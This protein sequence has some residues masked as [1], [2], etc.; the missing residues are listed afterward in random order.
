MMRK[1][2]AFSLI[3]LLVVLT[4]L[5]VIISAT[6]VC[7]HGVYRVDQQTRQAVAHAAAVNRLSLQFRADAHASVRANV[8]PGEGESPPVIL[9][10]E[11][12]GR[13]TEY[14]QQRSHVM[15]TV[16]H[17]G[18]VLQR[19]G[20]LLRPGSI[21]VWRVEGGSPAVAS[22]DITPAAMPGESARQEHCEAI[23]GLVQSL[24]H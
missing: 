13:T 23:V 18:E 16:T 1:R 3:E 19:E 8:Q 15:R 7:L 21:A 5:G 12:D 17:S 24:G 2:R 6:A 14:R 4:L 10:A 9:F 20:Y 22:L 11:L